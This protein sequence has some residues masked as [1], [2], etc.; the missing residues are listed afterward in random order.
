M[1]PSGFR[2]EKTNQINED[3]GSAHQDMDQAHE[4]ESLGKVAGFG[5]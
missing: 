3:R 4:A 2:K 5:W 1:Q